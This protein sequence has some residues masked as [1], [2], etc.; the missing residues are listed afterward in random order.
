MVKGLT[1]RA[2][3]APACAPFQVQAHLP[4]DITSPAW[5]SAM[6]SIGLAWWLTQLPFDLLTRSCRLQDGALEAGV[7]SSSRVSS[8]SC[9]K[10]SAELRHHNQ[11]CTPASRTP[12]QSNLLL[13]LT[14]QCMSK[15]QTTSS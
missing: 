9:P 12:L 8:G 10:F 13:F 7:P 1:H 15:G 5:T 2:W 6:S 11:Q 3:Y 14:T 4:S